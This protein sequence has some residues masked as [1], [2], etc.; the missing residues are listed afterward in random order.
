MKS[1]GQFCPVAKACEIV[2]ERW[3]PLVLRE[4]LCG[5]TRFSELQR[6]VPLM[7]RTLLAQRLRELE[8]AGVVAS[9]PRARGRGREYRLTPAG[10][11]A[12]AL[13]VGLGE[14]GQRWARRQI[15]PD[16]LDAELLAWDM[17]RRLNVDRLPA[18]RVVVRFD[19]RGVPRHQPGRNTWWLVLNRPEVDL[20]LKDPGFEVDLTVDADLAAL[21]RVWMG[22]MRLQD[23]LRGALIRPDG[24]RELVQAF[25]TWFGL[26]LFA[27]VA[28]PAVVSAPHVPEREPAARARHP[29]LRA[30]PAERAKARRSRRASRS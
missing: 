30:A 16:D 15:G 6:G 19:L 28:R 1:Y 23:A 26:S 2:A 20:C 18:R 10:E 4:L 21:T 9:V 5:S 13:I 12:R 24:P 8:D 14:W 27:G 3:T 17:H 29:R 11:E 22:D 25:P 7:S